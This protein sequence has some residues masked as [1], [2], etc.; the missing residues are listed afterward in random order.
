MGRNEQQIRYWNRAAADYCS[1][2][3]KLTSIYRPIVDDLLGDVSGKRV[4]DAGCGGGTYSR[5]L[6]S[7]G[8]IVTGIDGSANMI[9]IAERDFV[10][11][12]GSP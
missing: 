9:S 7:L 3:D 4:L 6:A 2:Q 8:A 5:K 10:P 12:R 11:P 1:R